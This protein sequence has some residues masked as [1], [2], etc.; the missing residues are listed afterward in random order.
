MPRSLLASFLLFAA[1]SPGLALAAVSADA[2]FEARLATDSV[3]LAPG[4][5]G[6][7]VV[8]FDVL[9]KH[10]LYRDMSAVGGATVG[11]VTVGE[12]AFP[13]GLT[14]Y[15]AVSES[16]R[17]IFEQGFEVRVPVSVGAG[18]AAGT[19]TVAI[20]VK[21]QGCNKPENYCLFP[22]KTELKATV[23][24]TGK[25]KASL[26][27]LLVGTAHAGGGSSRPAEPP[28]DF[29]DLQASAEV[30][31]IGADEEEHPVRAR[32]LAD[33]T[34]L[35]P[36]ESIRLAV[37]L[38]PKENWH[39]YWKSPGDIGLPT[40]IRW[41]LPEGA[42][43]G[44]FEFPVPER[45]DQE[46][47]ISYGYDGPVL[48]FSEVSLPAE[49][50]GAEA[51]VEAHAEW[52]VCEIMC[53]RGEARLAMTLPVGPSEGTKYA[54]LMDHYA[55]QHPTP[56]L[57]LE[58]VAVEAA[59]SAS[60]V[61]PEE[62]FQV[63]LRLTP[64]S[65]QKITISQK[66]GT[67][68][69]FTPIVRLNGM[70]NETKVESFEDGAVQVTIEAETFEADELPTTDVLG[71]L[72]QF[73]LGGTAMQT[74]VSLPIVWAAKDAEV[75]ASTSPMFAAKADAA[76]G[77]EPAPTEE[78]AGE[79]ST[80]VAEAPATQ[81][82]SFLWMLMLAFFGGMLLNIMPCVLPVLTMKLYSLIAQVDITPAQRRVAGY[83]YSAGI[84]ASFLAL[85]AAVVILKT[86]L[87]Q[88]V[89]WG[90]QFQ[91]PPYVAALAT[92]VF[93][94]GLSLF[95]VF[96]VPAFGA[97]QAAQASARDGVF[98]YFLT[99]VFATL[100]AT[101]CSAPFLGTGM[102]FAF[103]LPTSGILLFF[104]VAGF[105]LAFPFLLIAVVPALYKFMPR[106]G[107][108]MET[109]KHVMGF[110]L[111]AT[112][113][114]LVDVLAG[115]VGR[116]G[117]TGFLA[118]L[119]FVAFGAWQIGRFGGPMEEPRRQLLWLGIAL[120]NIT[121][122]G[123]KFLD[124]EFA[125][126]AAIAATS[127]DCDLDFAEEIP[128]KP[129]SEDQV[130]KLAGTPIFIDFTADWCLTCKVN[131]KTILATSTVRSAMDELGVCPLKADWTRKDETIS[132]WLQRYGKAGVPFYLV[133]PAD[134]KAEPIA[135]P[136]VI[137]PD[138]VVDAMKK[139]A[140]VQS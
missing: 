30:Q 112:T 79:A 9:D 51:T 19:H 64:T 95:G 62:V 121:F 5:Q 92:I 32:L 133:M 23:R 26:L 63:A 74:E 88:D 10:F 15:D 55:G 31:E 44:P 100:L 57:A 36:G 94:F 98:G 35:T 53:I 106:P 83:A 60:A 4:A 27:D 13:K 2:P 72:F 69:A 8:R 56:A 49:L 61:R 113:I 67:W 104:G 114:W 123:V 125:E 70:I 130:T 115:Q 136:E 20:P 103:S 101:P 139:A 89:L 21:Y 91:Y 73:E 12:G 68:P 29:S 110:S 117:A 126:P 97:N 118:F 131:E 66:A 50:A 127:S 85:A 82:K 76:A 105:G 107:A 17:E 122:G 54:A 58:G 134:P 28:V 11:P 86:A 38:T 124:L 87:G 138:L 41:T 6:E 33:R 135:L 47:I 14:K 40:K 18:A 116:D 128:W 84:V 43:A 1:L 99:G 7:L 102:G 22:V 71:G 119:F 24:V 3:D 140:G 52:L 46:G 42:E 37:H 93:A 132:T 109:F 96:E 59:V 34:A 120:A 25:A 48:F 137:T 108:W 45:F 77:L 129:F 80:A 81:D 78:A 90:F 75:L 39:T 65:D 16:E 111:I